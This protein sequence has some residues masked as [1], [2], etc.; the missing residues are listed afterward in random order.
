MTEEPESPDRPDEE[1]QAS[2]DEQRRPAPAEPEAS[3]DEQSPA[4][5]EQPAST[6]AV[7]GADE[8]ASTPV[9]TQGDAAPP[10]PPTPAEPASRAGRTGEPEEEVIPG[11]HLEPDLVLEPDPAAS[12]YAEDAEPAFPEDPALPEAGDAPVAEPAPS[13]AAIEL[14][15]DARYLGTGKRKTAVARVILKPGQGVYTVNGRA[16][17]EFF[18]RPALQTRARQSLDSVGY[19]SRM[20]VVARLHGGGVSS[21]AGA[22]RHGVA[23]ALVEADP[24]LRGELKKRGFLTRDAREKER[25]KAG[26]KKARKR[27]QFSKR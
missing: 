12:P 18:P 21:Q 25:K 4:P 17:E 15:Q 7:P 1:S 22:L 19:A 2:A 26:L 8:Q 23:R 9:A 24:N 11:A 27:P 13:R 5:E 14:A 10:E 20:D 6:E 3:S 16:L